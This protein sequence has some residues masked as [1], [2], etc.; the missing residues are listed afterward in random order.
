MNSL[1]A[2]LTGRSSVRENAPDVVPIAVPRSRS[3]RER[4]ALHRRTAAAMLGLGEAEGG[5]ESIIPDD[6]EEIQSIAG[7]SGIRLDDK[8]LKKYREAP[9]P[10]HPTEIPG[11]EEDSLLSPR[12]A[13]VAPDVTPQALEPIDASEVPHARGN[14]SPEGDVPRFVRASAQ[15]DVNPMDVLLGRPNTRPGRPELEPERVVTAE[16]AQATVNT[17]LSG[18]VSGE[19]LL[20]SEVPMPPPQPGDASKIMEAFARYG[21]KP[22]RSF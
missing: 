22:N 4:N 21:P 10:D 15:N 18:G 3:G 1:V 14:Q 12:D 13:L 16:S 9:E 2:Q 6:A 5:D 20:R 8:G 17:V 19:A 11:S 7:P